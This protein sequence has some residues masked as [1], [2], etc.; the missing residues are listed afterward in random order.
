M[1]PEAERIAERALLTKAAEAEARR[2]AAR[3]RGDAEAE[4]QAEDEL[5]QLWREHAELE[6]VA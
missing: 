1:R 2:Q 6:R 3:Q 4:R 5:R